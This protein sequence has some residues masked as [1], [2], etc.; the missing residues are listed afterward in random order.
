MQKLGHE[1][2]KLSWQEYERHLEKRLCWTCHRPTHR[3]YR[4]QRQCPLCRRKW[5]YHRRKIEWE[6]IK[7]FC[8]RQEQ[9]WA[10]RRLGIAYPTA[11]KHFMRFEC[12]IRH[13]G[14]NECV[15]FR[16]YFTTCRLPTDG[17]WQEAIELLYE[18]FIRPGIP[19]PTL[20]ICVV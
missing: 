2:Q 14:E 8:W 15:R 17:A 20:C 5:S 13:A 6:L 16:R 9:A 4:R 7:A 19:K 10:A 11:W 3:S 18:R 1:L 12:A